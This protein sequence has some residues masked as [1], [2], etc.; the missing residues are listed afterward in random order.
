M[1]MTKE[2]QNNLISFMQAYLLSL[3]GL[4]Q[5]MGIV[6]GRGD[7]IMIMNM[8]PI[9]GLI[10][11]HFFTSN[12]K[13]DL[14]MNKKALL[15]VYYIVSVIA[16]YKYAYRH[17]TYSYTYALVYCFI[18]IY[19]S[20]YKVDV[21]KILKY[22]MFF[23]ALVL[24]VSDGF[25]KN[26]G[27]GIETIGMSTTY[28]LLPFIVAAALHF[29]YYR[30]N[31]G[32]LMRIGYAINI[33]YLVQVIIYGNRGPMVALVFLG[34]YLILHEFTPDGKMK[35]S[36]TKRMIVTILLGSV[37]IFVLSN[38]EDII[39]VLHN[40]LSSM[41]IKISALSKSVATIRH[42]DLSNG[43]RWILEYTKKGIAEK[44]LLG[45]GISTIFYN[46]NG[47]VVYPHNLF[48]QLWY[49][50]GIFVSIPMFYLIGK[51]AFITVFKSNLKKDYSIIMIL[52]F[53]IAIPRLCFSTEFWT[54]IPFWFL[55][56]Y[57]ISPNLYNSET[58]KTGV[59]K[60]NNNI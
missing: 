41:G 30:K 21:E 27:R 38:L 1:A 25:F 17:T 48:Y 5:I 20:F 51:A 3:S 23:S 36:T 18:P 37:V 45:N 52:L 32:I 53:T 33:F 60:A 4:N 14:N 43:R 10:A 26:V 31:V 46:S 39:V 58:L 2:R 49:D 59:E 19:L 16:V 57:T 55:I 40:W 9:A 44:Y 6:L 12:K 24:P 35:K 13:R 42:G 28:N 7:G 15:F 11:I 8:L 34:V 56:M 22:M 47:R 50:L 54:T 29:W